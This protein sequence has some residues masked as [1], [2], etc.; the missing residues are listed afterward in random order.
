MAKQAVPK[1]QALAQPEQAERRAVALA[2]KEAGERVE[3][4]KLKLLLMADR[5]FDQSLVIIRR[6]LHDG[7]NV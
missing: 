4:L 3:E 7:K 5:N 1:K 6:W 2:R